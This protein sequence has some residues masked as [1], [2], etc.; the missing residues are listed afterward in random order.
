MPDPAPTLV[1]PRLV[2]RG[3]RD[4]DIPAL[5]AIN[6][7]PE[8]MRYIGAGTPLDADRTAAD[9]EAYRRLWADRGF[10]RFAVVLRETGA[11]AGLAGMAIPDDLPEVM[12]AVE[13]GWRFGREHWGKGL[14][15]EAARAA[16]GF[17]FGGGGLDRLVSVHVIGNEASAR[18]MLRLGMRP[19]LDAV[20]IVHHRPVRVYA[21][22]RPGVGDHPDTARSG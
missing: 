12:P 19:L 7:D 3:W 21:I 2:L 16:M 4:G 17:A 22:D 6:A 14:A 5:A 20:E 10:G 11:F 15:T 18:V 1:T 13:I 9:V 8:V